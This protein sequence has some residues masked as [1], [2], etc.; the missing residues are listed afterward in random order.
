[1][2]NGIYLPINI[3]DKIKELSILQKGSLLDATIQYSENKSEAVLDTVTSLIFSKIKPLIDKEEKRKK[4]IQKRNIENGKKGGRPKANSPVASGIAKLQKTIRKKPSGLLPKTQWVIEKSGKNEAKKTQWVIK[5]NP[6]GY[7]KSKKKLYGEW[8]IEQVG[9]K[10]VEAFNHYL[11]TRFKGSK[12][13]LSNLEYWLETYD[14]DDIETAISHIKH[15]YWKD[16]M[17]PVLM[18]RKKNPQGE[19]VDYISQLLNYSK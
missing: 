15:S 11:G 1:M 13:F 2:I 12:S 14:L 19:P 8:T 18:F 4:N 7:Q 16:K 9:D 10:V 17:T 6:V 5:E 3:V